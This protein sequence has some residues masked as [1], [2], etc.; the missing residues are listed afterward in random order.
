MKKISTGF[1][2]LVFIFVH[3]AFAQNAVDEQVLA[4]IK[5]EGFQNSKIMET[6]GYVTDVFGARLTN[7]PNL[8]NAQNWTR[9]RMISWGFENVRLEAWGSWGKGWSAD[10]F[11]VEMIEPTY[12]R[13]NAYPLAWTP[14]TSGAISGK[15]IVVSIRSNADFDKYRGKLRG[16]IVLNGRFNL[17]SPESRF[18]TFSKRF[19]DEE[20][21]GAAQVTNPAKD[22]E[23]NGGATTNYWDE[24]KDWQVG[25]VRGKEITKFFKDEGVA[26]LIQPSSRA[27]GVLSVQGYYETDA[28]KNVPA[29]VVA[30]EQYARIV[31]LTDRN[32]PVKLELNLQTRVHEDSTG[33]NVVGEIV[34]S[35][36][37]LKDEVVMLG[38][39]FDSWHAATGATDNAA[40]CVTMMEALRILKATGAK[41]RRT[42]RVALWSGE[43]QDY[44]G[45]LGYVKKHFGD[46]ATMQLKPEHEKLAAYYNLDNGTG[47]IRGVFLQGNEAA[48]PIFEEYLKPFNYL[49]AKTVSI[50]NTGG[51]DHMTFDAVGLPGF[52]FIQDPIDYDTRTHHTNLD[53]LEAVLEE[54]LKINAVIIAA[55]AYQTAMRNEKLP[56]KPLP[57]PQ[58]K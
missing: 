20:L 37:K 46:P 13:L 31:R 55:F 4:R 3:T 34:G 27:N 8:K 9:E 2:L 18:Q 40:G 57:Q 17:N 38:G 30:R 33:Y 12:D 58:T 6:L 48:R 24:E 35:D 16:A 45:S 41:P 51:T 26:A 5:A 49:G 53:V 7:S 32:V 52:Q 56:R 44:G 15:P 19:T 50:L 36:P 25:L 39:H 22:G 43:E 28:S 54:D 21:A 14:S 1:L 42:I 47:K 23:I 11:S 10:K 29:F